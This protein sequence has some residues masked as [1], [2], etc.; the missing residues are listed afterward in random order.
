MKSLLAEVE[1]REVQHEM[2]PERRAS[3]RACRVLKVMVKGQGFYMKETGEK[4][5]R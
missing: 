1:W 3:A 5:Q 2:E 4:Q